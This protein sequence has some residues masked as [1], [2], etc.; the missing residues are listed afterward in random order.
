[1]RK[2][3]VPQGFRSAEATSI[4]R[5]G[6]V[7]GVATRGE[8]GGRQAFLYVGGKLILLPGEPA[9]AFAI[10]DA[11]LVA[12]EAAIHGKSGTYPALW[13]HQAVTGLGGC[14]GG[15][16]SALNQ[17]AQA[18]GNL[19]DK[20]GRYHAFLWDRSQGMQMIGPGEEYSSAV[21]INDAGHVVVQVLTQVFLY[22]EGKLARLDLSADSPS[23]AYAM[24]N[25]DVVV[26]AFGPNS[27][28]QRAFLWEKTAGFV[29][30]NPRIAPGSGWRLEVASSIN[31]KGEIAGWGDYK[32]SDDAGFLLVPER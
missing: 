2:I 14:C 16:A 28:A 21:A 24:N 25:C 5:A 19:Y 20:Q 13:K 12:G 1:L 31:E 18:V 9:K 26:G 10:S 11:D 27:D 32:G 4:N 15:F 17:Q 3:A 22:R 6:H 29:D 8:A 7:V 23:Q 30:L